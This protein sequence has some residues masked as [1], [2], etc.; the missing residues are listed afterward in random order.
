MVNS[1]IEYYAKKIINR[2]LAGM[3]I[4]KNDDPQGSKSD[5]MYTSQRAI[6]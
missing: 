5:K 4:H 6:A 1:W 3:M 2:V